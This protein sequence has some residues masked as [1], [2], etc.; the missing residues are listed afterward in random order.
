M[1]TRLLPLVSLLA[2]LSVYDKALACPE[3]EH[4]GHGRGGPIKAL[5]QNADE[6]LSL[7]EVK[8]NERLFGKFAEIDADKNGQLTRDELKAHKKSRRLERSKAA[9]PQAEQ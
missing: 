8:N 7:D 1:K 4:R 6:Q 2:F 5:D 9:A 3:G